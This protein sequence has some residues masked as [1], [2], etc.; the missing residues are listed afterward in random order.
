MLFGKRFWAGIEDGSVTVAF[1]RWRRVHVVA[2]RPYRTAGGIIDVVSVAVVDSA[3]ITDADAGRAGYADAAALRADLRGPDELPVYRIDFRRSGRPDPRA[4]L[5]A[6]G[7][8][9]EAEVAEIDRRL[10]RLD[11]A[12]RHGPWTR[13]TMRLIAA[14]PA[15]RAADLAA[16]LGRERV[17][18]KIDVRKLKNLGLT[19]SLEIGYRLSARGRAYLDRP[20]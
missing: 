10:D 13:T 9:D 4:E 5:A 18:F 6:D 2:G 8:L 15:T 1:R 20:T 12:S 17:P 11:R 7:A 16:E 14:R 19:E 3:S